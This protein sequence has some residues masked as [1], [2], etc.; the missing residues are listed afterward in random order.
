MRKTV[1]IFINIESLHAIYVDVMLVK[2][3]VET[4]VNVFNYRI[5]VTNKCS[6]R[7]LL[8]SNCISD[9]IRSYGLFM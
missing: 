2:C 9:N 4:V 7:L 8:F 5:C 1:Y 3:S 6:K